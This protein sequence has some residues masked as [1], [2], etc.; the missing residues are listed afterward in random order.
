MSYFIVQVQTNFEK[1]VLS[2]LADNIAEQDNHSIKSIYALD[3]EIT[4]NETIDMNNVR[5]YL[6]Q[7]R[8]RDYLSN[9]RFTYSQV[10]HRLSNSARLS[11]KQQIKELEN[12]LKKYSTGRNKSNKRTFISGYIFIETT[13]NH[14]TIPSDIYHKL[15]STPKVITIPNKNSV[16]KEEIEFY[17][18]QIRREKL[19]L[20]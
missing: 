18:S 13:A 4:F 17:F 14:S 5:E 7:K 12:E 1:Y 10:N 16:P 2:L 3:Q 19:N 9:L 11:Y 20:I 6:K 8:L 15:K